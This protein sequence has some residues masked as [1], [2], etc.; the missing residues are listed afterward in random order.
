MR[1]LHNSQTNVL[2]EG[3]PALN[4]IE[5][6]SSTDKTIEIVGNGILVLQELIDVTNCELGVLLGGMN[7]VE[8]VSGRL[9]RI[10]HHE[11]SVLKLVSCKN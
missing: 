9:G 3:L 8:V 6:V 1:E 4:F 7:G 5:D 11:I 2:K 10:R